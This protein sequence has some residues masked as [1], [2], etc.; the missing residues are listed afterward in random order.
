V[1]ARDTAHRKRKRMPVSAKHV[2][3]WVDRTGPRDT[4]SYE[5]AHPCERLARLEGETNYWLA[6]GGSDAGSDTT[7]D[8]G[9][10]AIAER[11]SGV[12]AHVLLAYWGGSR[13]ARYALATCVWHALL[14]VGAKFTGS[15]ERGP[16][17]AVLDAV[18]MF[19]GI[20]IGALSNRAQRRGMRHEEYSAL[21]KLSG[22]ILHG[23]A[24]EIQPEWIEAR[25]RERKLPVNS[26]NGK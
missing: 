8:A 6:F 13:M 4:Y 7:M 10:L 11:R 24:G 21:V 22:G 12:P 19:R 25:F 3:A 18:D 20:D 14:A 2:A 16:R 15:S 9:A 23:W 1:T 26:Y 5:R 17:G